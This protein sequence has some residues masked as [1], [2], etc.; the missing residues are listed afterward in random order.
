MVKIN[1]IYTKTGDKGTTRLVGGNPIPK[2]HPRVEAYGTIDELNSIV[3]IVRYFNSQR[4]ESLRKEKF[5]VILEEIQQRLFDLG[6]Q[7]ATDPSY[8]SKMP[9][10]PKI[11]KKQIQWLEQVIDAMNENLNPLNS[12]IL[13]G[14]GALNSFLHQCRT[15]CRRAE[16]NIISL[17]Q[18]E[19]ISPEIISFINRL[20]DAFFV[21]SRWLSE[22]Q[23]EREI[24][25]KPNI[26]DEPDWKWD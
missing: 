5:D 20:S 23:G 12:F 7:L 2:N 8:K 11:D 14:G 15:V 6:S 3:G 1:K 10:P 26:P 16:R 9:N 13:P 25:W 19:E 17:N 22:T 21:F 24:L 18:Q 4:T